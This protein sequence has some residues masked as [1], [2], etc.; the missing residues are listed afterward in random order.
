MNH[1]RK[2][3]VFGLLLNLLLP[4]L[5][6]IYWHEYAF[7]LFVF[8]VML[9]A[10]SLAFVSL[11]VDI[12]GMALLLLLGLPILFYV[13]SFVDLARSIGAKRGLIQRSQRTALIFIIIALAYQLFSP[14]APASFCIVNRPEIF[15]AGSNLEPE[16]QQGD[17]LAADR[18]SYVV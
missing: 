10:T 5:G 8:L 1:F 14:N 6:H 7:G 16:F 13:F 3:V 12:P 18:L 9:L 11:L 15:V 17:L 4:G 2:S